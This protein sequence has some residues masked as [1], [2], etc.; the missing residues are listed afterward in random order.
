MIVEQYGLPQTAWAS[1]CVGAGGAIQN[2]A[3]TGQTPQQ[4][5]CQTQ[6]R[7]RPPSDVDWIDWIGEQAKAEDALTTACLRSSA[8]EAAGKPDWLSDQ[9]SAE[10]ELD[11]LHAR[12]IATAA[13]VVAEVGQYPCAARPAAMEPELTE[14][15]GPVCV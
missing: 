14:L 7:Q 9:M 3:A 13:E 10:A 1:V 4:N 11:A 6:Q 15:Y 12:F 8:S 2:S 5:R